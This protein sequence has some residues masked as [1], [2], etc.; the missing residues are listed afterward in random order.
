VV[1]GLPQRAAANAVT[2]RR[3]PWAK[4]QM[5]KKVDPTQWVNQHGDVLYRFAL[6]RV[7]NPSIA[8]EL[9][10]ETFLAAL[11]AAHSYQ[12]QSSERTWLIGILK[13]KLVDH[14]R[15]ARR[16]VS[17]DDIEADVHAY[18]NAVGGW[19]VPPSLSGN[20]VS[21]TEQAELRRQLADCIR[22]L[23]ERHARAFVL[24]QVDGVLANETCKILGV[25]AT[26]LWVLLHRA[27]LRLR[28]CLETGGFGK[29][30]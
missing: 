17:S 9:V 16:E 6:L 22:A 10:Q 27:R 13:H 4:C 12:E 28:Q 19:A 7:R 24:T 23:P 20:P 2:V 18:F 14:I 25:S 29:T 30:V 3:K 5:A 8:E 26:N 15:Q 21:Q 1:I 11:K